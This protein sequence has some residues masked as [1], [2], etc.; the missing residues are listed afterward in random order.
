MM[1]ERKTRSYEV[2]YGRPPLNSRSARCRPAAFGWE[3]NRHVVEFSDTVVLLP[4]D[5]LRRPGTSRSCK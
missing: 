2:G 5:L 1:T 3:V 4:R